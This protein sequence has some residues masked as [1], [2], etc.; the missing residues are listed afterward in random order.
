MTNHH[1]RK[2]FLIGHRYHPTTSL[3]HLEIREA[4]STLQLKTPLPQIQYIQLDL[5]HLGIQYILQ[6]PDRLENQYNQTRLEN[7]CNPNRLEIQCIQYHPGYLG[8]QYNLQYPD[9]LET[10][11][12]LHRPGCPDHLVIQC[13]LN[14]LETQYTL[15]YPAL[16]EDHHYLE[17]LGIQY[18]QTRLE[19]QCNLNHLE[20]LQDL[21]Y[22]GIRYIQYHLGNQYTPSYPENQY[23][24]YHL[25]HR[26]R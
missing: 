24:Q 13:N 8:I 5:G 16:L 9:R 12:T 14:R 17:Y 11:Y 3:L 25:Y 7:Q 20:V 15:V 2:I 6:Y 18:N 26:V 1:Q 21:E 4:Y 19:N 22:L 10:Q 23:S